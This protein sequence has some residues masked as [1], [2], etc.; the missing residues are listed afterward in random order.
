MWIV[1][2][3]NNASGK[4]FQSE[5]EKK[6]NIKI[7]IYE[8][9][10]EISTYKNNKIFKRQKPLLEN[11]VFCY[12]Q[13]FKDMQ[14]INKLKFVKGLKCFLNGHQS[15]QKQIVNF[16]SYCKS[17]ENNFGFISSNF[18][19]NIL[20]KKAQF[21]SGPFINMFFSILEKRKNAMKVLIKDVVTIVPDN[22]SYLFRAV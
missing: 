3:L 22:S 11:Y 8:P 10:V 14:N 21:I 18:F 5:I 2:K 15:N 4:F 9:K 7:N 17:Y 1:A 6:F 16:I 13:D 19:K 20:S 12:H